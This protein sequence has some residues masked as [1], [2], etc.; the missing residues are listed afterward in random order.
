[1]QETGERDKTLTALRRKE[2]VGRNPGAGEKS[3]SKQLSFHEGEK[4][5]HQKEN[6]LVSNQ[7]PRGRQKRAGQPGLQCLRAGT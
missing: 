4:G 2:R 3:A 7:S 6:Y 5:V 1:M